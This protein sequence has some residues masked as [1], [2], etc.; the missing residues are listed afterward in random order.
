VSELVQPHS[1]PL[2]RTDHESHN[3]VGIGGVHRGAE[4]S[5]DISADLTELSRTPIAVVCAGVKTVLD[6]PRTLE[7]GSPP[8]DWLPKF[9]RLIFSLCMWTY[10]MEE[11]KA[12]HGTH[13]AIGEQGCA[14]NA[15]NIIFA[16]QVLETM[17][18]CVA[19]YGSD[20][21]PAFFTASSGCLAP[22]RVDSPAEA[23]ALLRSVQEL[24]LGSGIVIGRR[25]CGRG[26]SRFTHSL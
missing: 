10:S 7:V 2:L 20:E 4:T 19:A 6:I 1:L 8:S 21:F 11:A 24:D 16:P 3:A 13:S 12:H 9:A 22:A 14:M 23:A 5:M 18:V 15:V 25:L 26:L 17:G